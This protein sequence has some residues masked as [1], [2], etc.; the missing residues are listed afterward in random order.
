MKKLLNSVLL[1]TSVFILAS[2]SSDEG[3]S[4][5]DSGN[6]TSQTFIIDGEIYQVNQGTLQIFKNIDEGISDAS[7][8]LV[9]TNGTKIGSV[10]FSVLYETADGIDGTYTPDED[11]WEQPLGTYSS[12]LSSYYISEGQN[13]ITSNQP[14]GNVKVTS[15]GNDVYTLEFNVEYTNDVNASG[16]V[17]RSFIVQI[18]ET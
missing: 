11:S 9:G 14:V 1:F 3:G 13:M 7:I 16:N 4:S 15:H 6:P 18:I 17:K 10:T 8:S 12:W 5:D 2:C